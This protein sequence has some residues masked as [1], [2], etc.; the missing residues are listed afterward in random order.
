[1]RSWSIIEKV[2]NGCR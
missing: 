2:L 1:V